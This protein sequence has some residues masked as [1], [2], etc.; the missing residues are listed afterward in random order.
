[1]SPQSA[2][3]KP[4][5]P[6]PSEF[7]AENPVDLFGLQEPARL[8]DEVH[9][10][11][12]L[13]NL[14]E[15]TA[16]PVVQGVTEE[17]RLH[18]LGRLPSHA[19]D[20]LLVPRERALELREMPFGVLL[21][22]R[23]AHPRVGPVADVAARGPLQE[24]RVRRIRRRGR[25]LREQPPDVGLL[26][27]AADDVPVLQRRADSRDYR[28]MT[29]LDLRRDLVLV[30]IEPSGILRAADLREGRPALEFHKDDL[31][32]LVVVVVYPD[33]ADESGGRIDLDGLLFRRE[34]EPDLPVA[35]RDVDPVLAQNLLEPGSGRR[36]PSGGE[37]EHAFLVLGRP[38]LEENRQVHP[39]G[40]PRLRRDLPARD[41]PV[42]IREHRVGRG[43]E[44]A[45]KRLEIGPAGTLA[46]APQEQIRFLVEV[47][48]LRFQGA[49]LPQFE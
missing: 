6:R 35:P 36:A 23:D 31:A 5:L 30:R 41:Q 47:P 11:G 8:F 9:T 39:P 24:M 4:E 37:S 20:R 33:R 21:E 44:R 42:R 19:H 13:E 7:R 22:R 18:P 28:L 2:T 12:L 27:F 29:H 3:A 1:M 32:G 26:A 48:D 46:F 10:Q 16:G 34:S 45:Q 17:R 40:L 14:L 38:T 43:R 15:G 25:P 49:L